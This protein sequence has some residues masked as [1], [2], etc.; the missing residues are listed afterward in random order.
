MNK[1]TIRNKLI[2]T[3]AILVLFVG[4]IFT[5]S[6]TR[7]S[8]INESFNEVLNGTVEQQRNIAQLR[9]EIIAMI[10][11]QKKLAITTQ[12]Q[13]MNDLKRQIDNNA[14]SI[15]ERIEI[16]ISIS[17]G[18]L[19]NL[20]Q[21]IDDK[22]DE[23]IKINMDVVQLS[24]ANSEN[25]AQERL[26]NEGY[27]E[28]IKAQSTLNELEKY[29][30]TNGTKEQLSTTANLNEQLY[31][32]RD[33]EMEL[34]LYFSESARESVLKKA[35]EVE[36]NL[37]YYLTQLSSELS[38][39]GKTLLE[40]FERQYGPFY[41]IHKDIMNL[42]FRATNEKALK[43][44]NGQADLI[45]D[46]INN[47][48]KQYYDQV[49]LLLENDRV[50]N[51]DMYNSTIRSM[52]GIIAITIILSILMSM[53]LLRGITSSL[54][55]ATDAVKKIA[56][57]NFSTD[58]KIVS[59]DEI[60]SMLKELQ[61]MIIKL[62]ASVNLAK[63]VA[64]G[65]LIIN[66]NT[67]ENHGGELDEAL[68]QMVNNLRNIVLTI[69]NGADNVLAASQQVASVSQQ[70][71][72]GSQEQAS[73][74]EEVSSSMEQMSA[75]IQQNTESSRETEKIAN[76]A[77]Q[78]IEAT[79]LS[80][81]ETAKAINNI[82][83]KIV[84]IEEIAS[85]TDLLALNAAVE[86]A[87]AGEH[88]KGFAVVAAEVRKLAERSQ[89][90]A[91]EI[92]EISSRTVKL[93]EDSKEMLIK[94]LPDINRTAELVQEVAAASVEQNSG[95]N[96]VNRAIQQLSQITQNNASSS[97][98]MSSNAEELSTQAEEL[99][100]AI[101]YFKVANSQSG[102]TTSNKK[103]NTLVKDNKKHGLKQESKA[104]ENGAEIKLEEGPADDDFTEF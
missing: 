33:M 82:A 47:I 49:K 91:A 93:A 81:S 56:A 89:Q 59:E 60:G 13:E 100:I 17:S 1:L 27:N 19:L 42:A 57:G 90:A 25:V 76:K 12:D 44:S 9:Y 10:R 34:I 58:V 38:G 50:A 24:M 70:L 35:A 14:L 32:L 92:N 26:F 79:S 97:E 62:R 36:K 54:S 8:A 29:L 21:E 45:A 23:L 88:G 61:L 53:W 51:N 80:V 94:T 74:A 43:I 40:K 71:S 22:V 75:N 77:S 69:T 85:K 87:R 96:Q 46:E 48:I 11:N 103:G 5:I 2:L 52:V 63:Q 64:L 30:L 86:A 4:L 66:F 72:Q 65:D 68:E 78:D 16:L 6:Y 18:E 41:E 84:I 20:A 95:A 15:D 3:L 7:I 55:V 39:Q 28:Y 31:Q 104:K 73:S 102:V 98:E 101:S 99:K 37:E 83:E 67:M